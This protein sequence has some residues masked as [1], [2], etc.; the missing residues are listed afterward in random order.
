[1]G[2][3]ARIRERTPGDRGPTASGR[4]E[5]QKKDNAFNELKA[6]IHFRL[7]NL[8]DLSRLSEAEDRV[9]QEDLRR[10]IDLILSEENQALSLPDKERL[11]KEIRDELLG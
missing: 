2:I 4:G 6:K 3:M 7:I 10:G 5:D 8:L 1:M 11:C 9:L